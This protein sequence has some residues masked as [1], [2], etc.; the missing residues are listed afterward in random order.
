MES[1]GLKL[2]EAREQHN[3]SMEQVARDTHISKH[4]L[5]ALEEEDFT[6]LPGETYVVGFLRNY[7]EYLS[8]NPEEVVT[9][10]KNIQIQEQPLPMNELLEGGGIRSRSSVMIILA[11]AILGLA[12]GGY[13]LYHF[14]FS[15]TARNRVEKQAAVV[16]TDQAEYF[17]EEAVLTRWFNLEDRISIPLDGKSYSIRIIGVDDRLTLKI[18]GGTVELNVGQERFLDL[19]SDFKNDLR[20]LLNDLDSGVFEKR[21]NIGLYK[22]TKNKFVDTASETIPGSAAADSSPPA[23]L[24]EASG[25][26]VVIVSADTPSPFRLSISFRGYCLFRYLLD[27]ENREERFFHKGENFSL[28]VKKS[29][30]LWISNASALR[31]LVAG[32]E[33]DMGEPGEVTSKLIRWTR[34]GDR[35]KLEVVPAE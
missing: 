20:I 23:G 21:A 26:N 24:E 10:Y 6:V 17:L 35:Y 11:V 5:R 16:K 9:L 30:H 1:L 29:V 32:R 14:I 15:A 3:Y 34:D 31:V 13:L 28:D 12:A 27:E 25:R 4:Y 22:L 33:V 19:N 2:K 7:A 18:P 8:L